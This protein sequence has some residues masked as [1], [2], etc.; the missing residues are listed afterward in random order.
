MGLE[1]V[2]A[3]PAPSQPAPGRGAGGLLAAAHPVLRRRP[4]V[5]PGIECKQEAV[6]PEIAV[7]TTVLADLEERRDAE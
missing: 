5:A 7:I 1:R 3:L 2:R 6:D 4:L